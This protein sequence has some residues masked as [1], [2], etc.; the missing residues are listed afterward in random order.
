[1]LDHF[2]RSDVD[3][4]PRRHFPFCHG[5]EIPAGD[6][7]GGEEVGDAFDVALGREA[8]EKDQSHRGADEK[9]IDEGHGCFQLF[10]ARGLSGK[11][12][13]EMGRH[14]SGH[15]ND[16]E[17][18]HNPT[19]AGV[20]RRPIKGRTRTYPFEGI[21]AILEVIERNPHETT[22]RFPQPGPG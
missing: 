3:D 12:N 6:S 15:L 8:D 20:G 7:S 10:P 22:F 4:R 13:A 9:P 5:E 18:G 16:A 11:T 14:D 17:A 19:K 2:K 1:M 21:C